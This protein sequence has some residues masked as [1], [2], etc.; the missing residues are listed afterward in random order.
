AAGHMAVR[1]A[2]DRGL[3]VKPSAITVDAVAA[4]SHAPAPRLR[5][6]GNLGFRFDR[7]GELADR[8]FMPSRAERISLGVS[9]SHAILIG[10]GAAY[11]L[12]QAEIL[13]EWTWDLHVG[14]SAP[15][16]RVSPMR[17]A[18]GA[19]M[20]VTGWLA[21]QLIV[22]AN[23]GKNPTGLPPDPLSPFESGVTALVGLQVRGRV[24]ALSSLF[25]RRRLADRKPPDPVKDHKDG[26]GDQR[27]DNGP[28]GGPDSDP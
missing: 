8:Y 4:L 7:S 14:G 13:A 25:G 24:P 3:S 20:G 18:A 22:E 28:D 12:G 5:V 26:K 23:L 27:P 21:A 19:R 16:A 6:G 1:L 9:E 11:R 2:A 17:V 15:D 10:V